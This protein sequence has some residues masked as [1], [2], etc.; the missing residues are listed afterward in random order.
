[1]D[2]NLLGGTMGDMSE[3]FKAMKDAK[4]ER[5]NNWFDENMKLIYKR[6]FV[7]RRASFSCLIYGTKDSTVSFYPHTGR[8]RYKNK[9]YRGGASAFISW[10]TKLIGDK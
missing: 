9:T 3:E 7:F 4:K 5:H 10:Y 1:M 6:G 2:W 8:W